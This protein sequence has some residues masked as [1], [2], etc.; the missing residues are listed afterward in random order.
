MEKKMTALADTHVKDDSQGALLPRV[1][2]VDDEAFMF[3]PFR[4]ALPPSSY[5][6][7]FVEDGHEALKVAA[8]HEFDLAFVDYF[9]AELNGAE[10]AHKMRDLQP[11]MKTVLMSCYSEIDQSAKLELAGAS[12]FLAKPVYTVEFSAEISRVAEE[13]LPAQKRQRAGG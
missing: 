4:R 1:L 11:K 8:A 3:A 2:V 12:A 10:I 13:L 6:I 5:A 9:L 7:T